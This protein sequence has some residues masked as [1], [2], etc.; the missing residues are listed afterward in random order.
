MGVSW[1]YSK[2]RKLGSRAQVIGQVFVYILAAVTFVFISLFGYKAVTQFVSHSEGVEFLSFK[3]SLEKS[4]KDV[5]TEYGAVREMTYNLPASYSE[6]CLVNLEKKFSETDLHGEDGLCKHN[7]LAC[8]VASELTGDAG[9]AG[10]GMFDQNVF[11][12]PTSNYPIKLYRFT[13]CEGDCTGS[14]IPFLCTPISAGRFSLVLEG[15]GDHT[16]ISLPVVDDVVVGG[17]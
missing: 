16:E 4:V 15:K 3:S 11:L 10:Y 1:R 7:A 2:G 17:N 14:D 5:Y 12:T 9:E 6:I 8:S 13:L